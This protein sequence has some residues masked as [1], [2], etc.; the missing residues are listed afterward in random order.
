MGRMLRGEVR[1]TQ[2]AAFPPLMVNIERQHT[3]SSPC[4]ECYEALEDMRDDHRVLSTSWLL[5]FPYADVRHM[6]TSVLVVTDDEPD[7]ARK[8]ADDFAE[9][10]SLRQ[11]DFKGQLIEPQ[12]AIEIARRSAR[13]VCLLDMGD[14]IGGGSPGDS[15]HLLH[16]L[17]REPDLRSFVCLCDRQSV[18][19]A[20]NA[21][22]AKYQAKLGGNSGRLH[23]DPVVANVRV[24]GLYAG[25]YEDHEP[26][27]GGR[28]HYDM[29]PTAVL[30]LE[31]GSIVMVTARRVMPVSLAQLTSCDLDPA[32]FDVLV[33]KG[34]HSPVAAYSS[35]CPTLVRVH[36]PGVTTADI[37]GL[38]YRNRR[39]PLFP[40]EPI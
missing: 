18:E 31:A 26:R 29:G 19:Q 30:E 22:G 40:F 34:V 23:G 16:A 5:G 3:A 27:H 33:A 25:A 35:V 20:V 13:P 38:E 28:T 11:A 4:R 21:G 1:P 32:S 10:L 9:Y 39:K 36:T 14:N 17:T 15:T 8:L 37:T 24:R 6:G 12:E 2:A 7:L